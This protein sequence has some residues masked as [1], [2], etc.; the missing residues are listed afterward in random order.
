MRF[1]KEMRF[2]GEPNCEDYW[3]ECRVCGCEF[4]TKCFPHSSL[5]PECADGVPDEDE[6]PNDFEDVPDVDAMIKENEA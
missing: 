2:C 4:C 1:D 3:I 6:A 5:C